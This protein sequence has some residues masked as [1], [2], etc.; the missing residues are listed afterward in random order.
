MNIPLERSPGSEPPD[1]ITAMQ[2]RP[3]QAAPLTASADN[4]GIQSALTST[5]LHTVS[6]IYPSRAEAEGVRQH[7]TEEGFLLANI[8]IVGDSSEALWPD[9]DD[10]GRDEVLRDV[11][12]DGAI[13]TAVGT[14]VGVVGTVALA[15]ASVTLFVASPVVAPLAMLGWFAGLG[16]VVGAAIGAGVGTGH[17]ED[18]KE[19]EGRFSELVMD[20]IEEGNTALVV[21]T[22]ND[23]DR[24]RAK[25]IIMASLQGTDLTP[26][27]S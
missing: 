11:L 27:Q 9:A 15:E 4:E 13:G 7:L 12:V 5:S 1:D 14:G 18:G 24:E 17:T 19:R 20:A 6:A 26:V 23:T 16:G 10:A 8:R 3:D 25:G 2:S 22:W 21:R